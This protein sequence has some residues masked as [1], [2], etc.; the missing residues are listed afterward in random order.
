MVKLSGA[1]TCIFE[2][3]LINLSDI[4]VTMCPLL[5]TPKLQTFWI[6]NWQ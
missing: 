5:K 1:K 3:E 4:A 2:L 6:Y